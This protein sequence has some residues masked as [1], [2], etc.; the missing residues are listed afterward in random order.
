MERHIFDQICADDH[1]ISAAS[2]WEELHNHQ[3]LELLDHLQNGNLVAEG[4]PVCAGMFP[5]STE[6]IGGFEKIPRHVWTD[7]SREGWEMHERLYIDL[8]DPSSAYGDISLVNS[9]YLKKWLGY[10]AANTATFIT[11]ATLNAAGQKMNRKVWAAMAAIVA[12]ASGAIAIV[13]VARILV[14]RTDVWNGQPMDLD[15][16]RHYVSD[17]MDEFRRQY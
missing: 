15:H 16:L 2:L 9:V 17:F 10:G 13:E 7:Q 14:D 11:T 12:K 8:G 1:Y 5:P 6:F 3:R 4:R